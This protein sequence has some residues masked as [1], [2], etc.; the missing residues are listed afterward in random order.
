LNHASGIANAVPKSKN[1]IINDIQNE[2][3]GYM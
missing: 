3:G 1:M 2:R